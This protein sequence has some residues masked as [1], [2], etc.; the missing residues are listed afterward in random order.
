M[1]KGD[2]I[3]IKPHFKKEGSTLPCEGEAGDLFVFTPLDEG[4]PDPSPEGLASLWFCTKGAEKDSRNAIWKR[5]QF[6]DKRTCE[7]PPLKPPQNT[8]ELKEG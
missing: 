6:D 2:Q 3:N 5:V 4:D 7:V 1:T 8:P